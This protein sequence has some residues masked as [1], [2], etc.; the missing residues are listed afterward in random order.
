MTPWPRKD[1]FFQPEENENFVLVTIPACDI[2]ALHACR[3]SNNSRAS[4]NHSPENKKDLSGKIER[5]IRDSWSTVLAV[6]RFLFNGLK[7]L[8][9]NCPGRFNTT[10]RCWTIQPVFQTLCR[11]SMEI[12]PLTIL[13]VN[14]CSQSRPY[15]LRR[16]FFDKT[17]RKT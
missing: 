10:K 9:Q 13:Y 11:G 6:D 15:Y 3:V 2:R 7:Q 17:F 4:F 14:S 16:V 5:L 8:P 1:V 12:I